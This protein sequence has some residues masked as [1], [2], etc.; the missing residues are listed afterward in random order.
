L[1]IEVRGRVPIEE[2]TIADARWARVVT[3][4][5]E[6]LPFEVLV[7]LEAAHS[8]LME[9]AFAY[10]TRCE[11]GDDPLL[12]ALS[13]EEYEARTGEPRP[14]LTAQEAEETRR[15]LLRFIDGLE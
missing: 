5:H 3:Q 1:A 7:E 11:P 4:V 14:A 2:I 15:R 13:D 8:E 12:N 6:S 10:G 9:I